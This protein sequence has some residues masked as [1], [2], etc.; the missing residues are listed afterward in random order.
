M[1]DSGDDSEHDAYL[2]KMKREGKGKTLD[3]GE[4]LG[5]SD[6]SSGEFYIFCLLN[7]QLRSLY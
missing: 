3:F 2:N 4:D 6:D 7:R 5:S 1:N